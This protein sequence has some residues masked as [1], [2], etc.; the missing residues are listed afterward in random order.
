MELAQFIEADVVYR[1]VWG[2]EAARVYETAQ[3]NVDADLL[4]GSAVTAIETGTF[5]RQASILIRSGFDHRLAAITAVTDTD[6]IFDSA[7]GMRQWI[8]GLDPTKALDQD[9]PAP[10]SRSAWEAFVNPSRARRSRRWSRETEDVQNVTWYGTTPEPGTWLRVTDAAPGKIKI[11]S[12]GFDALG[13][14]T[15]LL[16][17]GRQGILRAHRHD[18]GSGI[19]LVYRGP[20]DLWPSSDA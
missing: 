12:T 5:N 6:A 18:A 2:M 19:R 11:W 3:N 1:L 14:A 7:T 8:A 13:E 15:V 17:Q 16:D 10:A 4:S 9:W 20:G